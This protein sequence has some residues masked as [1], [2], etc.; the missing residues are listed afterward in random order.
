MGTTCV[1][2]ILQVDPYLFHWFVDAL[3]MANVFQLLQGATQA[4]M[5]APTW[6]LFARHDFVAAEFAYQGTIV[7][8]IADKGQSDRVRPRNYLWRVTIRVKMKTRGYTP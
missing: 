6:L 8:S 5:E 1:R 7:S 4:T 2:S 3:D